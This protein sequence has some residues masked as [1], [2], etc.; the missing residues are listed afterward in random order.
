M[1]NQLDWDFRDIILHDSN[2]VSSQDAAFLLFC[3]YLYFI[4]P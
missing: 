4:K 1:H 3:F 2:I